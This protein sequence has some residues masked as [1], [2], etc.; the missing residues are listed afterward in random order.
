MGAA[1]QVRRGL[2]QFGSDHLEPAA[3]DSDTGFQGLIA[4]P[5]RNGAH[6]DGTAVWILTHAN[7]TRYRR[8]VLPCPQNVTNLAQTVW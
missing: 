1:F 6:P 5:R 2:F 7:I 4:Q 3:I 8:P